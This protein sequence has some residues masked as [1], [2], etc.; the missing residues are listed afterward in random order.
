MGLQ[1]STCPARAR[2]RM[3]KQPNVSYLR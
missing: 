2:E 3:M 1:K